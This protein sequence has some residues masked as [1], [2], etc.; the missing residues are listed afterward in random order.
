MYD[1]HDAEDVRVLPPPPQTD[2]GCVETLAPCEDVLT[3]REILVQHPGAWVSFR[4]DFSL[5]LDGQYSN[6]VTPEAIYAIPTDW[7]VMMADAYVKL[8]EVDQ[9]RS[10]F[11]C[12]GYTRRP[13]A[14]VFRPTGR[15]VSTET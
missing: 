5:Q 14:V 15:I 9:M 1:E 13:T 3:L 4:R 12:L 2:Q 8:K 6:H 10:L 11:H 7:V